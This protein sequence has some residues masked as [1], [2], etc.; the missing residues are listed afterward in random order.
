M[1]ASDS[2]FLSNRRVNVDDAA[3]AQHKE[4]IGWW[5]TWT[6]IFTG[7]FAY[8]TSQGRSLFSLSALIFIFGG[9]FV[10]AGILGLT[11]WLIVRAVADI[12]ARIA[13]RRVQ[14]GQPI[15]QA[16]GLGFR[17]MVMEIGGTMFAARVAF[18]LL[19]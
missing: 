5:V 1:R 15:P 6:W 16:R 18:H 17:F 13:M 12:F 19:A 11:Y 4:A 14:K 7:G 9:M 2:T 8:A 10:A 3:I